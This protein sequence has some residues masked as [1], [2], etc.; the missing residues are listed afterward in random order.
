MQKHREEQEAQDKDVEM[1]VELPQ[2][3][4][5]VSPREWR[6]KKERQLADREASVGKRE[7]QAGTVIKT[8]KAVAEGDPK[9]LAEMTQPD[10]KSAAAR[11]FGKAFAVLRGEALKDARQ[12]ARA[13]VEAQF[14]E[15][16]AADDAIVQAAAALPESARKKIVEAR[17]SLVGRITALKR[18]VHRWT[19]AGPKDGPEV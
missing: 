1:P 9:V 7:K 18:A 10:G 12:E 3:V 16:K 14:E 2:H 19:K 15:I 8:A 5:H 13:K 11:L 4:E 6:E 17:Q